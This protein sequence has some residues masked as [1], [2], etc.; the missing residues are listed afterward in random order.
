MGY[1]NKHGVVGQWKG[2]D[3]YVVDFDDLKQ[4][5][6]F[7][8]ETIFAVRRPEKDVLDLVL[9]GVYIGNLNDAGHVQMC[10]NYQRKQYKWPEKK[11]KKVEYTVAAPKEQQQPVEVNIDRLVLDVSGGYGQYSKI[12]DSFFE[13]LEKLW[14]EIEV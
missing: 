2:K 10:D 8:N 12:V 7:D 9:E 11:K 1:L 14:Q 5:W 3:V 4:E 13:G 6:K